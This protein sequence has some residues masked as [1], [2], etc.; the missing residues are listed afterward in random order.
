MNHH[1]EIRRV[2]GPPHHDPQ[3]PP[4]LSPVVH[5]SSM[6]P[7]DNGGLPPPPG[8]GIAPPHHYRPYPGSNH[9]GNDLPPITTLPVNGSMRSEDA[10]LPPIISISDQHPSHSPNQPPM[11]HPSSGTPTGQLPDGQQLGR[12]RK[13][14]STTGSGRGSRSHYASK[15]VA[16]NFCRARKTRCDGEHPACGACSRRSLACSYVNDPLT[17]MGAGAGPSSTGKRKSV[18]DSPEQ[19]PLMDH[20]LD[21]EQERDDR[22]G[23]PPL[24]ALSVSVPS[25][26]VIPTPTSGTT[27]A[28]S[29]SPPGGSHYGIH[30]HSN[31]YPPPPPPPLKTPPQPLGIS[32]ERANKSGGTSDSSH[33]DGSESMKRGPGPMELDGMGPMKKMR[34]GE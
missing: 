34:Y 5:S 22:P 21:R 31:T 3:Q 6:L 2:A 9:P 8:A 20:H 25:S 12:P 11:S 27:S 33:S 32:G 18:G 26:S 30:G 13:R 28:K 14:A 4:R 10:V 15:I 24:S 16:C 17:S 1:S 7:N 19:R 29:L 23:P